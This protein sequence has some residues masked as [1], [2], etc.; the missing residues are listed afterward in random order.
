VRTDGGRLHAQEQLLSRVRA[1]GVR[2]HRHVPRPG[3]RLRRLGP[4][5]NPPI[6]VSVGTYNGTTGGQTLTTSGITLATNA[7][8]NP[9]STD[10]TEHVP[11][12]ADITGNLIV[13]IDQTADGTTANG[14]QF[15]PAANASGE[16]H[17]GY[18]MAAGCMVTVPTSVTSK[19]G[20][21]TDIVITVT[22]ST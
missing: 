18:I 8:I 11:L 19:A 2:R 17:P 15:Y 14:Y 20:A 21:E 3:R 16:T 13:E 7:T 5:G 4:A 6:K 10:T 12:T 22:G 1:L 9:A